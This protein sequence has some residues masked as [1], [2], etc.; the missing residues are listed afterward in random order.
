MNDK[1]HSEP[2]P[3]ASVRNK[4]GRP[5]GS[6][7]RP[8]GVPNKATREARAAIAAFV[9]NNAE[10]LQEWLDA[11]ANGLP[12]TDARGKPITDHSGRVLW[13]LPPNPERA[14]TMVQSVIEYHV[15]KLA[16]QE[17]TGLDGGP[18]GV[19]SVDLKGLTDSELEQAL[20]LLTK[21]ASSRAAR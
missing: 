11:V 1:E 16:R 12:A 20:R 13:S 3:A 8:K 21:A 7:G 2:S 19:A 15:P 10:R 6:G 18:I 14:F 17:H 5:K 4:G 9:N